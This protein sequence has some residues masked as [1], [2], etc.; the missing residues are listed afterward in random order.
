MNTKTPGQIAFEAHFRSRNTNP[1]WTDCTVQYAWDDT[2][3]AVIAHHEA[4]KAQPWTLPA[5][6]PGREWHRQDFT[7]EMLPDGW[8][9]LLLGETGDYEISDDGVV[10]RKGEYPS[11]PCGPHQCTYYRTRR[12]LPPKHEIKINLTKLTLTS[13][14]HSFA[15][16]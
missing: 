2:A 4:Q 11:I 13:G 1:E 7:E 3:A 5:P 12:P 16:I 9:P 10:W 8:R 15:A 6:P 14:T